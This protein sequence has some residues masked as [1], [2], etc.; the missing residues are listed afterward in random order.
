MERRRRRWRNCAAGTG[1]SWLRSRAASAAVSCDLSTKK[2]TCQAYLC[3]WWTPLAPATHSRQGWS[4]AFLRAGLL[5]RQPRSPMGWQRA[6]PRRGAA[7][8][9]SATFFEGE[10]LLLLLGIASVEPP[11]SLGPRHKGPIVEGSEGHLVAVE[12]DSVSLDW[13]DALKQP[14]T[15]SLVRLDA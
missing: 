14:A 4:R 2:S 13:V 8:Q 11:K 3:G 5:P 6:S 7:H 1:W 9:W 12:C 15:Q 10:T